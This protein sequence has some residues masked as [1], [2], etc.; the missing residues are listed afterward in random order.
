MIKCKNKACVPASFKCD[1][2]D[3]CGDNSDETD[4]K[5]NNCK[6]N[7]FLTL[8]LLPL[9]TPLKTSRNLSVH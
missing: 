9:F 3:D 8:N 7:V 2:E 4:C 6:L 1:G 5:N